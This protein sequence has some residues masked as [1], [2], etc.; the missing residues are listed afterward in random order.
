MPTSRDRLMRFRYRRKM[1][2]I[3]GAAASA[4]MPPPPRAWANWGNGSLIV[5]PARIEGAEFISIGKRVKIHEHVWMIARPQPGMPPPRL[6]IGDDVLINRFVKII[7]I[8][9]VTIGPD[10]MIGDNSYISDTHY[11]YDDPTLPIA[12][13]GLAPPRPVVVGA[14]GHI[15]YRCTIRPGVT[16]GESVHVGPGSV[17]GDDLPAR[18]VAYGDPARVIRRYD[19]A[20]GEWLFVRHGMGEREAEGTADTV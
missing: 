17:V 8:G 2:R 16:I 10:S 15:G 7:C 6:V 18:S 3:W 20:Q 12:Q 9:E 5:H 4:F 19:E 13:Q 14:G 1:R 11:R